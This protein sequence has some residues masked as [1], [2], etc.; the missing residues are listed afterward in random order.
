[1]NW[2]FV[3][4]FAPACWALGNHIDKYLLDRQLDQRGIGSLILFSS[5]I[6]LPLML[7]ILLLHPD[8]FHMLPLHR[9]ITVA[10]GAIY[11]LGLLPYFAALQRDE[12]SIVVP[13]FQT[14]SIFSYLL[15]LVVL[16]EQ[17]AWWQIAAALLILCGSVTV[18]LEIAPQRPRFKVAVFG[19]MLLASL[20]NA[21]NWLLFKLVAVQENFWVTSFWEYAGF[22]LIGICMLIGVKTYRRDFIGVLRRSERATLGMVTL[23]E[24]LSIA[25]KTAT[26]IASLVAPLA[27]VSIV[28]G[29]QPLFVLLYGVLLT[30][31]LP[32]Y[33]SERL[34]VGVIIQKLAA[35]TLILVGTSLLALG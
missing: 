27:L 30:I 1:M 11:V 26:N 28:H 4:L 31:Y 18:S 7:F 29:L 24:G 2:L 3:A 34:S 32:R 10:N 19:W 35:L 16:G 17:L 6:G 8:V 25:A 12:A 22:V 23:N 33:G 9:A 21:L 14:T 5:L 20:L 13:L 15:G